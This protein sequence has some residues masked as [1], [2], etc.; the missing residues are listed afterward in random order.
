M[1]SGGGWVVESGGGWVV[2]S[3]GGG[4]G[5]RWWGWWSQVVG[6]VESGG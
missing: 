2:E 1:E 5:V 4:G 6:V 3:G